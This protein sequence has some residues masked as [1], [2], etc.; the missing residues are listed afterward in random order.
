MSGMSVFKFPVTN[1]FLPCG[2]VAGAGAF[3]PPH[4]HGGYDGEI[5]CLDSQGRTV[6]IRRSQ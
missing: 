2:L 3:E 1:P 4:L 6:T 5:A